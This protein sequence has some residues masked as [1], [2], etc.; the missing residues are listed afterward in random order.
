MVRKHPDRVGDAPFLDIY[1]PLMHPSVTHSW[2][3]YF[4]SLTLVCCLCPDI[5]TLYA[6]LSFPVKDII[7]SPDIV[8]L[9]LSMG[10]WYPWPLFWPVKSPS[11]LGLSSF[12][13]DSVEELMCKLVLPNSCDS[14][15]QWLFQYLPWL[16][17]GY[18]CGDESWNNFTTMLLLGLF[19]SIFSFIDH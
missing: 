6:L 13:C 7:L 3:L 15:N 18:H 5:F 19:S 10:S 8:Q 17:S 2:R 4:E 1:F 9:L 12:V 11:C 14:L 16:D